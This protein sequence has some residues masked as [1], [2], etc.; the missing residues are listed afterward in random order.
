[1]KQDGIH[2][3]RLLAAAYIL[4]GLLL[5]AL[6]GKAHAVEVG[7]Q[8][9]EQTIPVATRIER[10]GD[11]II[12]YDNSG[13]RMHNNSWVRY[14]EKFYF[15]NFE[16]KAYR[17]VILHFDDQTSY[18]VNENGERQNGLVRMNGA[19]R[20]F[21]ESGEKKDQMAIDS[22]WVSSSKGWLFVNDQR[23][24]YHDQFISFGTK[25]RYYLGSDGTIQKGIVPAQGTVYRMTGENGAL[26][27]KSGSYTYKGKWYFANSQGQPYRSQVIS[28]GDT[29]YLMGE[30]GSRQDG[31]VTVGGAEY[32]AD[33]K[34][35]T[36]E[37]VR[38]YDFLWPVKGETEISSPFGWRW[39]CMHK[40]I[41]IPGDWGT[42][43]QA[44]HDAVVVETGY[45]D[46]LGNYV[47]MR[48]D[49][50][51]F[52]NYFHLSEILVAEG[53]H[54]AEGERIALMGSTGD[55]TGPHLHFEVRTGGSMEEA[56]DPLTYT[57]S[58]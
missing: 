7:P 10:E 18:Y 34:A 48:G 43:I 30:D 23:E 20:Y 31:H 36:V 56:H 14:Q 11:D 2:R 17:H 49:D 47:K 3:R 51:Y 27:Q 26:L 32:I 45:N 1:M 8:K 55:S 38:N 35:G 13:R 33:V 50:G 46:A 29:K 4:I 9:I 5:C 57:F 22:G 41:D 15:A 21:Y 24:V 44:A 37:K 28:F 53:Q 40:G 42:P 12:L 6:P 58:Y 54:V 39:G 52:T 19:L 25:V 16:G